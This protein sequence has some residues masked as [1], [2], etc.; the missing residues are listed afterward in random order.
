MSTE[1]NKATSRGLYEEVWN[2][3][4]LTVVDELCA[5]NFIY[6]TTTGPVHG[7]E[8]FKQ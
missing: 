8:G 1:D 3:G 7:L 2:Q 4:N 5:P 6:H